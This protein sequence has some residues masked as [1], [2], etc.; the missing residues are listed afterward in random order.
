MRYIWIT[1]GGADERHGVATAGAGRVL[2]LPRAA[3][4]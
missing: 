3:R 1:G 4:K 2:L